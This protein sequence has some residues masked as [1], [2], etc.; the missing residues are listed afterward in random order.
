[1]SEVYTV[2]GDTLYKCDD[3]TWGGQ[4]FRPEETHTLE[5]IDLEMRGPLVVPEPVILVF[6]AGIDHKPAGDYISRNR[7][8]V[9]KHSSILTT[10]RARFSMQPVLLH[11]DAYYCIVASHFPPLGAASAYWQYDADG[12]TYPRGMRISTVDAGA[13][14]TVHYGSDH[15][16]A[17]FG[18]PPLP[19]PEPPPPIKHFAI[20]QLTYSYWQPGQTLI[21]PTSIPCHLT[22]YYTNVVPRKHHTTS[23]VRGLR[24][25]W[26]TYF[27][28]VAWKAV[29]QNEPGD[30]L[31][32]T[33]RIPDWQY[34]QTNWFT[35]R[36]EVDF[37]DSPSVGPIFKHHHPRILQRRVSAGADDTFRRYVS[38]I[39]SNVG[40]VNYIGNHGLPFGHSLKFNDITI[41]QGS[42][43]KEAYLTYTANSDRAV[44]TVKVKIAGNDVDNAVAP[45]S[46]DTYD[47]MDLLATKVD[48][49][50]EPPWL[51]NTEYNSPSIKDLVQLIVNRSGWVSGN[52]IQFRIDDDGSD[53]QAA[54]LAYSYNDEPDLA[55]ALYIEHN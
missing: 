36:G 32:H 6:H 11:E 41:P 3:P 5:Y 14:W 49:H 9:E 44:E 1:M 39:W 2:G 55:P 25:P 34:C 54:R 37:I 20:T 51:A 15:I 53:Y 12:A 4:T 40:L 35:F 19:K 24:V 45:V 48:W 7:F 22:C 47:N 33:F 27:C 26:H 31:Y 46:M 21:L 42:Y 30:T 8:T 52:A 17:E 28:F 18:T 16:F 23:V 50:N 29:E 43:I 10:G 38:H 13:T